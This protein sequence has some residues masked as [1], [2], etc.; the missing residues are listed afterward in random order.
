MDWEG[1]RAIPKTVDVHSVA[2]LG[3][4]WNREVEFEY[5]IPGA[6]EGRGAL[7]LTKADRIG[8]VAG[9]QLRTI[10]YRIR[11]LEPI[12]A[13]S[14]RLQELEALLEASRILDFVRGDLGE[15]S[16]GLLTSAEVDDD[17]DVDEGRVELSPGYATLR[18]SKRVNV[19]AR[20]PSGVD[21]E[22]EDRAKLNVY[23]ADDVSITAGDDIE[24][25]AEDDIEV[26]AEDDIEVYAEDKVR[27]RGER[28]V[29]GRRKEAKAQAGVHIE[30]SEG[31]PIYMHSKGGYLIIEAR[32]VIFNGRELHLELLEPP[33]R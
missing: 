27:I 28:K 1:R 3:S 24:V 29:E 31:A 18:A 12:V 26:Y 32:G 16:I 2:E 20:R 10:D 4:R 15:R 14:R 13:A 17:G 30:T 11:Q 5:S 7:R 8:L 25:Y 6:Q 19:L 22:S 21:S 23:A 9:E 33:S